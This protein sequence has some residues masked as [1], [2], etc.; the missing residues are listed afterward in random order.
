MGQR[1]F[2]L[3]FN[4][5]T[6]LILIL[7]SGL[8][9]YSGDVSALKEEAP[10][11]KK[12]Q[13]KD[14]EKKVRILIEGSS[15]LSYTIF[16]LSDPLRVVVDLAGAE[17]GPFKGR[18][19]VGKDPV[20]DIS[21][22]QKDRPGKLV[23]IEI[24]LSSPA[25]ITPSH[26]DNKLFIDILKTTPE[27]KG[28]ETLKPK[29]APP[30]E[31]ETKA[32][33]KATEKRPAMP[34]TEVKEEG[35]PSMAKKNMPKNT[36]TAVTG[37]R[38]DKDKG[39]KVIISGDGEMGYNAFILKPNKLVIDI[40]DTIN[41]AR[42]VT[43]NVGDPLLSNIRIGHHK[44]PKKKVR[45]VLDLTRPIPYEV[46]KEG[47]QL[48]IDLKIDQPSRK[49]IATP[50][51]NDMLAKPPSKGT[52]PSDKEANLGI[53][54]TQK[55]PAQ[56]PVAP[57]KGDKKKALPVKKGDVIVKRIPSFELS[58]SP[59]AQK[60]EEPSIPVQ[61]EAPP[62]DEKPISPKPTETTPS[63]KY[64]GKKISLDF[65]DADILSILRLISE[66]SGMNI[67][68]SPEV[69]GKVTVKILNVPWDQALDII[70]KTYGLGKVVEDNIIRVAPVATLAKERDELAKAKEAEAKAEDLVS[71][72]IPLGYSK[73]GPMK[74]AI[75]KAKALSPRG[76]VSTDERTNTL[77]VKDIPKN[78]ADIEALIGIL[79]KPTPQ[80]LIEAKIVEASTSFTRELG[81]QWGFKNIQ[82]AAH[83]NPLP[84]TFPHS[85]TVGGSTLTGGTGMG[86]TLWAVNLP[87]AVSAGSG[88]AIGLTLGSITNTFTLDLQLSALEGTG[89]GKILSNPKIVT[90]D[91]EKAL[92]K[93]G[94][95]IPYATVSAE[96]TKTEFVDAV[97]S[98]TVTPTITP[99]GA[100]SMK[101]EVTK[102]EPG[103]TTSAGPIIE[104]KEANTNVLVRDGE[105]IVIGGIMTSKRLED[106]SGIPLLHKI[107]ILGWL[108]KKEAIKED[109][110]E[111]L[112]FITPR[113]VR[114]T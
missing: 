105:T 104:K 54:E 53:E 35:S 42:P 106:T 62:K 18:M 79:D 91:N 36:A 98:L 29:E 76:N 16:K 100:I 37:V 95:K 11:L 3:R 40:P 92:I 45:I 102:D 93:Q 75:E 22:T 82:D 21:T 64:T 39:L 48:V 60:M 73:P 19:P 47:N 107:P 13:V 72:I 67:I 113:I 66:V 51:K 8:L 9:F 84:Y 101:I 20:I 69:K 4:T 97:L 110:S 7:L 56:K 55:I 59:V 6:T 68:A 78:L 74:D 26:Q 10:V 90:L 32:E 49:P 89:K 86:G 34:Q 61:K 94:R 108:F 58:S 50:Q 114:P 112:I 99:G 38:V 65:Q 81:I 12:I 41:K 111:L 70:L 77:I 52:M 1:K 28:E 2:S 43:I 85:M 103:A 5:F 46:L 24:G 87:A 88:G 17:A 57:S 33:I 96:G 30:K 31:K 15:S 14:E 44:D 71:K 80:V 27:A 63:G 109:T 83:G 25:D 23:R